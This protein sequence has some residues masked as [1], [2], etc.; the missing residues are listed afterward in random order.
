MT[1]LPIVSRELRVASRR[2]GTYWL[3]TLAALAVIVVGTW[4]FLMMRTEQSQEIAMVLFGILTGSAVLFCLLSGVRSTADSLSEEKREGT[5]GLLF[6]T[7]L[8]G[9]DV[10]LGKLVA[11]SLNAFYG[12]LA[13]VPVLGIPL[14]MGGVTLG[15][16]GRMSLVALNTLVFSLSIGICV[17]ALSKGARQA[18]GATFIL[19]LLFA[20]VF[21][22]WGSWQFLFG[23]SRVIVPMLMLPSPGFAYYLAWDIPFKVRSVEFWRSMLVIHALSWVFLGLASVLAPR[24]WKDRPAGIRKLQWRE[25]WQLWSYGNLAERLAFRKRLLDYNAFFWLSARARLKPAFVWGVLGLLTCGWVWGLSAFRREWLNEFTYAATGILL[26]VLLKGWFATETGRQ[27][28]EDRL[29]GTMELLLSTPL[30]IRDFLRGQFMALARQFLGP[31]I[32][33]LASFIVFL[34]APGRVELGNDTSSWILFWIALMTM[35]PAD[36][37]ALYWVGMW[38]GVV[39]KNPQRA[40]SATLVRIL[41]VPWLILAGCS[42]LISLGAM[43]TRSEVGFNFFVGLWIAIGAIVDL[44]FAA[45]ARTKLLTEFRIVAAQRYEAPASIWKRIFFPAPRHSADLPPVV[46]TQ[47]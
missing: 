32:V 42:L 8:R 29:H 16:F 36:L 33:V 40:A 20:A 45:W 11:S 5:L 25:R 38:Q 27:L 13:I 14:L 39:A 23:R 30:T 1:I 35:L 34:L 37:V 17:S 3:R 44:I 46:A 22:V 9:Y 19:I 4:F 2:A 24:G 26:N 43:A 47:K 18:R 12:I 31:L 6:L 10:V 15:E 28:A 7:D 41:V 21:P